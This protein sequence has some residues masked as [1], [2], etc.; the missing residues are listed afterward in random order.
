MTTY[1]CH[2]CA[3]KYGHVSPVTPSSGLGPTTSYQLGKFIK[4]T[5]GTSGYNLNS[6]FNDPLWSTY[7]DY[8][9][10]GTASGC[11][12]I[13]DK[14]RKNLIFFAG[15]ETGLQYQSGVFSA[16]CSGVVVVCSEDA[17]KIHAFPSDLAAESQICQFCYRPT[18]SD[19]YT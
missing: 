5:V 16:S 9:V 13:D 18:P 15:K 8:L 19:L 14:G 6:V 3:R 11:L 10:A 7:Q 12:Q 17:G 2:E 4:H 1:F